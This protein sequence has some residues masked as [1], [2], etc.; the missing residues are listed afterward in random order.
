LVDSVPT[1]R[2]LLVFTYRPGYANPFGDRT[3]FTRIVPAAL[4]GDDSARMAAAILDAGALP[5][6]LRRLIGE[7]AEGNP[8]Y[9]EELVKSL[10]ESGALRRD[11]GRLALARPASELTIPDTIHDVIAARIDRLADA[12]KRALQVAAVVGRE[13]TQRLVDRLADVKQRTDEYLREL[14]AL[15]LIHERRRYP[16]LAYMFKHALTQDV[17][18]G[19]LLV[20]R[21]RALHGLVGRAIEELYADRLAEHYEVLAHHF[22]QAEEWELALAYLLKAAEKATRAFGLRQALDLYGDALAAA[23][24]LGDRIPITTRMA[25]LRART[26]LFFGVGEFDRSRAEAETLVELARRAADPAAEA[27]ALAQLA[28]ALQWDED[29]PGARERARQAIETA[30]TVG[31]EAPVAA[32]IYVRGYI[33]ALN[34]HLDASEADVGRALAI[35][36]KIGDPSRQALSLHFLALRRSWQ[37]QYRDSLSHSAEGIRIAREHRL[38]IPLLRCLW[39]H[40]VTLH[41][42]GAHDDALGLLNEGA[43]LAEKIGDDAFFPRYLNTIGWARI[44]CGDFADGIA[45]SERSYELTAKSS[46]AGHATGA[47]RRAFIRINQADALMAQ[48]ELAAAAEALSEAHDTVRHPPPSRWMTWRYT[49]HCYASLGQLALLRGDAEA[50]RRWADQSLEGA[51]PSVSKKY[52]SWAWRIKGEGATVRR[53]WNEADEALRR[54]LAIAETIGQ[55]RQLWLSHLALGHL[56]TALGKK[57]EARE[58]YRAALGVIT[59][60]RERTREPGLRAGLASAP[61]MREIETLAQ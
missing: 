55:P 49:V 42:L 26:D 44:D 3:Y 48:G 41:E 13:F 35:A 36:R 32:A 39:N 53:A 8:F 60:V 21:R 11:D 1:L 43:A 40:G 34:G 12:P 27:S 4:S 38:A 22:S 15:E 24:R 57:D 2:A 59:T 14:A 51:T 33:N 20:Q 10:E 29:F 37:G 9:V 58:R 17:A 30:E 52:E 16:E 46:R 6:E 54:A 45:L 25:I 47:E 5:D 50:A 56:Q 18:Y 28:S 31:A 23:S 7:K 19:S 61:A